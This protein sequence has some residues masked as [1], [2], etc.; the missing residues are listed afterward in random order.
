MS[1]NS[2]RIIAEQ[3]KLRKDIIGYRLTDED[4][5][6]LHAEPVG[7]FGPCQCPVCRPDLHPDEIYIPP[8]NVP[9]EVTP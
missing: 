2:K 9:P 4:I 5:R 7:P 3:E 8:T 1:Q 6:T